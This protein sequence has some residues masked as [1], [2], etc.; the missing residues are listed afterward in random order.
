LQNLQNYL[1]TTETD[2]TVLWSYLV[3]RIEGRNVVLI[4]NSPKEIV[5]KKNEKKA[6]IKK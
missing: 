3:D 6:R 2:H 4:D 1:G 5:I